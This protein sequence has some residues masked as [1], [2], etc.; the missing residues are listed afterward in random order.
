MTIS[1]QIELGARSYPILIGTGLLDDGASWDGLPAASQALI[2][3]NTTVA[4]LYAGVPAAHRDQLRVA[5]ACADKINLWKIIH[6]SLE[7][8]WVSKRNTGLEGTSR[9]SAPKG[10]LA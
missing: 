2:V 3:T 1:L 9:R 6:V 8:F 5:G 10:E 4:P 7:G